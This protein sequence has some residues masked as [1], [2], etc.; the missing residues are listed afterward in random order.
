MTKY[1]QFSK[2]HFEFELK[3][4]LLRNRLGFMQDITEEWLDEGNTSWERIYKITTKNK[5]VDIIIFSSVD[6]KTNEV[7]DNGADAV[8]VVMRWKTK[9]GVV[10]KKV[11]KHY[12]LK[13]LFQNLEHTISEAQQMVFGLNFKEF[14]KVV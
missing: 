6:I 4:I 14:T 11:K 3:G 13:T 7:R 2:K 8:R 5:A 12:R 10:F 1:Y 9:N